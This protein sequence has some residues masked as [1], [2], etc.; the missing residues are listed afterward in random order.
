MLH[1]F[2]RI[3][4]LTNKD[5]LWNKE[6]MLILEEQDSYRKIIYCAF[7]RK[8]WLLQ[9]YFKSFY[10]TDYFVSI[11]IKPNIIMFSFLCVYSFC[12]FSPHNIQTIF[13]RSFCGLISYDNLEN[14]T[15]HV[16]YFF[17]FLCFEVLRSKHVYDRGGTKLFGM[18]SLSFMHQTDP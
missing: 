13:L 7:R 15:L 11:L 2:Y 5:P 8:E 16:L 17:I 18:D 12:V 6:N 9:F 14:I 3:L 1:I 4:L 10:E